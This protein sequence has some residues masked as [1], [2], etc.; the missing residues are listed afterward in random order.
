MTI[1]TQS[2]G[3]SGCLFVI[4]A[5]SGGGKTSLVNA[6]LEREPGIRLSVSYT[7]RVP[8]P[9]EEERVAAVHEGVLGAADHEPRRARLRV[10]EDGFEVPE[11]VVARICIDPD[12]ARVDVATVG[13]LRQKKRPLW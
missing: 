6:L 8:R 4:A 7:T 10:G 5:P 1:T 3:A 9:G 12:R 2:P 11:A 13:H